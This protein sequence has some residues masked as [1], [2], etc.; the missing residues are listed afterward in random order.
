MTYCIQLT[1]NYSS[2]YTPPTYYNVTPHF[3]NITVHDVYCNQAK[4]GWD[5]QGLD[6]SEINANFKNIQ[7]DGYQYFDRNCVDIYGSCDNSTVLPHCPSCMGTKLCEDE[8]SDCASY[9][10]QCS[11]PAYRKAFYADF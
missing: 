1:M 11:N 5:L 7:I 2:V 9:L 10:S 3:E 4:Y 6:D 8:S